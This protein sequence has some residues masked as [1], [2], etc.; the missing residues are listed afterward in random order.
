MASITDYLA[1][2]GTKAKSPYGDYLKAGGQLFDA[3]G[4]A[5]NDLFAIKGAN[6]EA[7]T[8]EQAAAFAQENEGIARANANI[9]EVAQ[10]KELER[11][12]GQE[13]AVTAGQGFSTNGGSPFDILHSTAQQGALA[14]SLLAQQGAVQVEGY[15]QERKSY[16]DQAAAAKSAAGAGWLGIVENVAKG[17]LA[18][19]M[20]L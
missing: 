11:V 4:G 14:Q 6:H 12:E 9:K 1:D 3:V 2:S 16:L 17:A 20:V 7:K 18:V 15:E 19:A 10:M 5:A 13:K 8:Y